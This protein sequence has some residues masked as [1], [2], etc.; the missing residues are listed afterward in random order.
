MNKILKN[1]SLKKTLSKTKFR[2]GLP[3][4]S[5]EVSIDDLFN[6]Q[7]VDKRIEKLSGIK[8]DLQD[9]IKAVETLESEALE[10]K[11]EINLLQQSVQKLEEDKNTAEALLKLPEDSFARLIYKSSSKGRIRGIIEGIIIGFS[12]GCLSSWLIW[13]L[14]KGL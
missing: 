8:N 4:F 5:Y 12:T 9:A 6:S 14:T 2:I 7:D 3:F 1:L 13:Y 10:K 11:D